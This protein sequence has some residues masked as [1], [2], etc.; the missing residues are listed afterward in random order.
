MKS[1]IRPFILQFVLFIFT[2]GAQAQYTIPDGVWYN[3]YSDRLVLAESTSG[4][5]LVK[6]I[7]A[8]NRW[9]FFEYIRQGVYED[10]YRNRISFRNPRKW[11]YQSRTSSRKLTFVQ[12]ESRPTA[13]SL[14]DRTERLRYDEDKNTNKSAPP[15]SYQK[16]PALEGTWYAETIKSYVYITETRE[17][18]KAR[19]KDS[20]SWFIYEKNPIDEKE[21]I[22]S[23]GSKYYR[24]QDGTL[25]WTSKENNRNLVLIKIS[26]EFE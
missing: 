12:I 17:G 9:T 2:F 10:S 15:I 21:F 13:T 23:S 16:L 1:A 14:A 24:M 7:H 18:L 3:K 8:V 22:T 4:G 20:R 6:G 26:D 5:I 19:L 11:I 25:V